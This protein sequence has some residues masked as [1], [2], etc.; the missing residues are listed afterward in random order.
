[1]ITSEPYLTYYRVKLTEYLSDFES[2][3]FSK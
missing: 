3:V 1:M 2:E